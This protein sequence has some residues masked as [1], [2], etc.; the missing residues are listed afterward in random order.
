[1]DTDKH[2]RHPGG[3]SDQ[4]ARFA[5]MVRAGRKAKNLT[6]EQLAALTGISSESVSNIERGKFAP[7]FEVLAALVTSL[8]LDVKAIFGSARHTKKI[9]AQ[10]LN[11]EAGIAQIIRDLEDR[12]VGLLFDVARAVR[13][14]ADGPGRR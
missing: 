9:T 10:R 2:P 14:R 5:A 4:L 13:D 1:M 3:M 6:Q 12:Q 7:T 11:D 8:E